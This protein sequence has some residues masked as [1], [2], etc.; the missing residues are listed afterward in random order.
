M[1]RHTWQPG[2][3]LLVLTSLLSACASFGPEHKPA[4]MLS[5]QQ[6]SLSD[7]KSHAPQFGWWRALNDPQLNALIDRALDSS[8]S[9]Q[10]ARDRLAEARSAVGLADSNLGPQVSFSAETDRQRYSATG[11]FGAL[12][13]NEYISSYSVGLN[14][15]WDLDLWGKNRAQVESALGETRAATY[16]ARQT[17]LVL[18]QSIVSQYTALQRQLQQQDIIHARIALA[19]S[20]LQLM[21]ARVSA[22]LLSADTLHQV[23]QGI[24]GL[25][26]QDAEIRAD[27]QRARH[28]LAA[29]SGQTPDALNGLVP[30]PLAAAPKV[31]EAKIT[32]NLLGQRPDIAGERA[33]VESL[34]GDVKAAKA[35]FYPD[36]NISALY[37]VNTILSSHLF[38]Y[39]SRVPYASAAFTLPIFS[40][41]KLQSNLRREQSRYDQA[42]DAYNQSVLNGLK[43]AADALSTQQ[44]AAS[45]LADAQR[46]FDASKK[47]A[48]AM[49]LRL[50]AGMAS[51]LD[52][53]DS[54]DNQ[55]A[56]Q[57]RQLDAQASAQLAWSSLNIAL[58]G[59]M[60]AE[61]APVKDR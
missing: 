45:Q 58:G 55:L 35:E 27:V 1:N 39:S 57:S 52:A 4:T 36:I 50:R 44:Q 9:M 46:G 43:E 17:A 53:L 31:E 16:Q 14:A 61:P 28:A 38:D 34:S 20:R 33:Q 59:G 12:V 56:Q 11:L 10:Q 21:R 2:L 19:D 25:K 13:G 22:G 41:G 42:V 5:A 37:G 60:N 8:P 40:S 26:S 54:M 48:Q 24:A 7:A 32:A 6:L 51:K 47:T 29:L 15:S 18:T 3:G 49:Q 23:E 30:S